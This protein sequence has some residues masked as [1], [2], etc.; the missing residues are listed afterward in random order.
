MGRAAPFSNRSRI[1]QHELVIFAVARRGG[2]VLAAGR[3]V[4]P[5]L[6]ADASARFQVFWVG[7]PRGGSVQVLAPPTTLAEAPRAPGGA[8]SGGDV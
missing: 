4:V 7:D 3:A 5:E 8:L 6:A 2:T 1:S